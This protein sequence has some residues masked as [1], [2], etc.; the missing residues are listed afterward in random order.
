MKHLRWILVFVV[1]SSVFFIPHQLSAQTSVF[2]NE[3]HY[4][5][6]GSDTG[7]GVE[8]AGPAG[9]DLS[10]WSIVFYN[11]N[12]GGQYYTLNLSGTIPD[13]Q[14]GYGT[15]QFAH[16]GIQ[17]G[18]PDGLALVDPSS[19]VIQF[20][21]YEGSFTATDGPAN[22]MTSTDIG[23][24]ESSTTAAGNSLQLS[25]TGTTYSD[26]SWNSPTANTFG[27]VNT[28]QTFSA[29]GGPATNV[30]INEVD[31]DQ[32][33]TDTAEF[34]EL[35]DGGTGSTD[36]SGLVLVFFNGNGD[37]SYRA[38]DLDG[39]ST[40][41]AG[42]FVL[43]A[44]AANTANC[45][46][47]VTPDTNLIQN[48]ADAIALYVGDATD[49][50]NGTAITTTNLIDAV[51]YGATSDDA[52]LLTLLNAGQ[53]QVNEDG[54]GSSGTQSIQRCP[55][56]SGGARN[57]DT[58]APFL[59]TPG[60]E[61]SCGGACGDTAT[62]IHDIQGNGS[63]SPLAGTT[64]VFIEG[65]VVGDYQDTSTG[66][67]GFFVQEEDA[68]ID[69]DPTTSEGI[70]VYDNGFGTDVNLGDTV[71][72]QGD[73]TEYSGLT[74]LTN[75]TTVQVCGSG[76][77]VTPASIAFPLVSIDNLE[78][79]EGMAVTF[80]QTLTVSQNYDLGRYGS[81]DLS[82]GRLMQPTQVITPGASAL[83]LQDLND[84]SRIILDDGS[85]VQNPDP[86]LYPQ[87]YGLSA[88]HTVRAGYT[89]ANLTGVLDYRYS[90]YRVQPTGV[91]T[92]DTTA[93]ARTG[94]PMDV[95]GT[96]KVSSFNV[97]NYFNGD[98]T[99][100]GFPTSRGADTLEEFNRQRTKIINAIIA[101]DADIVG[102]MEIEN[103]GYGA[104]SAIA[105][106][107]NGLNDA[108]GAGTYAYIDPGVSQ[109]G[110]DEIAVG[111]IYKPASV[112]SVGNAAI[113]DS[114]VD[115]TFN[116]DKNRP[117]LAQTFEQPNGARLTVVVNHLKSKGS[118]CDSIGDPDTGDGQ[119][120]CNLTR[121][122]AADALVNWLATDPTGSGDTDALLIGDMNSYAHEDPI[123]AF[124]NGGFTN[125][126]KA[127]SGIN[128]YSY[129]YYGESGTLDYALANQSL[130][131]QVTGATVW[132][133]NTD[134][135]RALDYNEEYK[136]SNQ[137]TTFYSS[138]AYRASDHDPVLIGLDLNAPPSFT[139]TPLTVATEDMQYTYSI[140]ASDPNPGDVLT[141]TA[142]VLPSWLSLT[143][144]SGSAVFFGST[145]LLGTPTNADVGDH[146]VSLL[147]TD[148]GGLTDTQSFTITVANVND[149]PQFTSIPVTTA[150]EDIQYTYSI[151]A[152]DADAGDVLTVTATI[153][154]SWL[155]LTNGSGSAVFLGSTILVGTPTNDDVGT[156]FVSLLVTDSGGLTDT[157][158]FTITVANVND[159]P[160]FSST[161]VISAT[162]NSPYTYT[163]TVTDVDANDVLTVTAT[164][165]PSWLNFANNMLTGTP[166]NGD[167]GAHFVSLLVTDSGGL[168]D[169][170]SFT[171]TVS[172]QANPAPGNNLI[173]LPLIFK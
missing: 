159:A 120:N 166:T 2:I 165:L 86:V 106:L 103:D 68:D 98:G 6:S 154:P 7:E 171:I 37:T 144:G 141:V 167:V 80:P 160:Q 27:S 105:D 134:E 133:I 156:H 54:N 143:N 41:A 22:G 29:G 5:N 99:G 102:L 109:I 36:L 149:A 93:N 82:L 69:T 50:P 63:V 3:I 23:V 173:F 84:R 147:V 89:V 62:L 158:S 151:T 100:G 161:P 168:T 71:R 38:F 21:S 18:A 136:S 12:G 118:S 123:V 1:F 95:G 119:G 78:A 170:Q 65:V 45:D 32:S 11:G 91:V 46:W 30:L 81:V 73:V 79:F 125:L 135:P 53:P 58:Y 107:V 75:P 97:L 155:S 96:L 40:T 77:G 57:T 163:V 74:E 87:P 146:F 114:S 110:T 26:F 64:G 132:H 42:Y 137:I 145:T 88:T 24:S 49:F 47:D 111:L 113:L 127:Y 56:G 10:G 43:C 148:S 20:L 28:G 117:S 48:G 128:E 34:L 101:L 15:L 66:L 35:Y 61:N 39:Y 116:S 19:N 164:T 17:N 121:T 153:L 169:T 172:S 70:F 139:S 25:G 55:N 44:N 67:R 104:N 33:G 60:E 152:T 59:P 83:S 52:E 8:I 90:A 4:D 162:E 157:Q 76:S 112:T 92:F 131:D 31:A 130:T 108:A 150:T 126:A 13:Q 16:S 140:T 51:V 9:T 115:P 94:A 142:T 138:D 85:T 14:N 124:E 72:V 129:I 122:T